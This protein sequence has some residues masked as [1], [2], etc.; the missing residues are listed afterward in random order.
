MGKAISRHGEMPALL[1]DV[2]TA[3]W[4]DTP[5]TV[6]ASLPWCSCA[7]PVQCG[8]GGVAIAFAWAGI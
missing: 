1:S 4:R 3:G 2:M 5:A 6:I 8:G 7:P